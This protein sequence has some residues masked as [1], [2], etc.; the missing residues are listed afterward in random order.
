MAAGVP[1]H[2]TKHVAQDLDNRDSRKV[3]LISPNAITISLKDGS[4]YISETNE[5]S[6]HRVRRVDMT[7]HRISVV[8]GSDAQ[9]DC[10]LPD[11]NC[12]M[13]DKNF[14]KNARLNTPVALATT[15]DGAL[16]I[17]D[18]LNQR[19]RK[20]QTVVP[21]SDHKG[22]FRI[23]NSGTN[24][25]Y[26]FASDGRHISTQNAIT[27]TIMYN[28]SRS[29]EGRLSTISDIHGNRLAIIRDADDNPTKILLPSTKILQ[30]QLSESK[31]LLSKVTLK[32]D[33]LF[34]EIIIM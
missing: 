9:C 7:N 4:L 34:F 15:S 28:F 16:Y 30:L 32:G 31:K 8:A 26:L 21:E 10:Q 11:C 23:S 2:C 6:I 3:T 1:V 33:Y 20:V 14:A 19:I 29:S 5:V 27:E 22:Q 24:E 25:L 12:F 18:Q 13:G 17:A